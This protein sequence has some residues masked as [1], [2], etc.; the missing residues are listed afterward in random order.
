MTAGRRWPPRRRSS[1]RGPTPRARTSASKLTT[2][3]A[4]PPRRGPLPRG[5][6]GRDTLLGAKATPSP[7][8]ARRHVTALG[9]PQPRGSADSACAALP[10]PVPHEPREAASRLAPGPERGASVSPTRVPRRRRRPPAMWD[11]RA[12]RCVAGGGSWGFEGREFPRPLGV[13]HLPPSHPR[14][15]PGAGRARGDAAGGGA[16]QRSFPCGDHPGASVPRCGPTHLALQ[17]GWR[18]AE[19]R[20]DGSAGSAGSGERGRGRAP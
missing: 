6:A 7:P 15:R 17:L 2:P 4:G 9:P 12:A 16:A 11:P 20:G 19:P 3:E 5:G 14:P 13:V 18:R 1:R 8:S 10:Q